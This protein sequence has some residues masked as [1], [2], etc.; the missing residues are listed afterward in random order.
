MLHHTLTGRVVVGGDGLALVVVMVTEQGLVVVILIPVEGFDLQ[1]AALRVP[2]HNARH[3]LV[4]VIGRA[5]G[6]AG[7]KQ[8]LVPHV[9]PA[10]HV[11]QLRERE[12]GRVTHH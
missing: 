6:V 12:S 3:G 5:G 11:H 7:Q 8:D 2:T 4:H 1:A 10:L 9:T